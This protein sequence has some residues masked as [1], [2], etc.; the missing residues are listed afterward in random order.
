MNNIGIYKYNGKIDYTMNLKKK[1]KKLKGVEILE[2]FSDDITEDV[3]KECYETYL[4]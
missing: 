4:L 2:T 3:V 1:L